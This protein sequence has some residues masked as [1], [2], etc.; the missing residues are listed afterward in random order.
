DAVP[1][2]MAYVAGSARWSITGPAVALTDANDGGQGTAPDTIT[3]DY[4][5]TVPGRVTAVVSRV[6]PGESR[7][8]TFQVNIPAA[9]G[10]GAIQNTANYSYDP[11]SGTPTGPYP[12][13]T[14]I[15]NVT[16]GAAVT[17]A[18]ATVPS[19]VQ[20]ATV[21]FT[22]VVTNTGNGTDSFDITVSNTSFPP[23]TTF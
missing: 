17:I 10:A 21:S 8:V 22:N 9:Q 3:Y 13:N 18:G 2:G 7:T 12:T 16:Q 11:G 4:N 1:N 15:F 20:G 14:A 6:Q 23:G 19:A 5:Q